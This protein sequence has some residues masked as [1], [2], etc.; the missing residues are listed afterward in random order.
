MFKRLFTASLVF[1]TVALG[2]PALA[3]TTCMPRD[4]MVDSLSS[5]FSES[6][7]GGGLQTE[8]RLIEIWRSS[9]SGSFTIIMTR[10][11]GISC[12]VAA[13]EYWHDV[14]AAPAGVSG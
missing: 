11:D 13:G 7:A 12:V 3:Q 5:K 4:H 1:G 8:Q 6:L 10:P 2:P 14:A 9:D